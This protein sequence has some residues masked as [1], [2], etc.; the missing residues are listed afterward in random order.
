MVRYK[1]QVTSIGNIGVAQGVTA[2][3]TE[4]QGLGQDLLNLGKNVSDIA[5]KEKQKNQ[6]QEDK[7]NVFN[8]Y[9]DIE[10]TVNDLIFEA[11]QNLSLIHISEPTRPY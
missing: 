2:G 10:P 11:Q 7:N 6:I 3:T 5:F 4:A 1:R 8:F 9:R